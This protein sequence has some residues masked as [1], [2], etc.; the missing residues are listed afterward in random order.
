MKKI[1]KAQINEL[2]RLEERLNEIG[3]FTPEYESIL[4]KIANFCVQHNISAEEY[5]RLI[6]DDNYVELTISQIVLGALG[7]SVLA[8]FTALWLNGGL[9]QLGHAL[10]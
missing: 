8:V 10:A 5:E 2:K 6:S 9:W 7:V 4:D 1:T 3:N